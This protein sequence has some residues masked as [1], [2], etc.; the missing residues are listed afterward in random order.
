MTIRY[1]SF[2]SFTAIALLAGCSKPAPDQY[3]G[4]I[5]M[6]QEQMPPAPE[7]VGT[8]APDFTWYDEKGRKVSFKEYTQ[9]KAVLVN[10]WFTTCPPCLQELPDLRQIHAAYANKGAVVIGLSSDWKEPQ[11]LLMDYMQRFVRQWDIRYPI[12]LTHNKSYADRSLVESF[13]VRALA[14][15]IT[16]YV[17]KNGRIAKTVIGRIT[18]ADASRQLDKLL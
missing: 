13:G 18:V 5:S 7:E 6:L 2:V 8:V 15:P 11:P 10:L 3:R 9:G 17:D 4:N 12:V 14:N 1:F 16:L